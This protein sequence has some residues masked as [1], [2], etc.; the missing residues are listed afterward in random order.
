MKKILTSMTVILCMSVIQLKAQSVSYAK[1]LIEQER[2]LDAAKQLRPLADNGDVEA[3]YLAATL[4]FEG[5][6]V[7]HNDAQ[8]IK[9]A[10]LSANQGNTQAILLLADHYKNSHQLGKMLATLEHYITQ[11]PYLNKEFV[12]LRYAEC[13][14]RGWGVEKDE[15]KAWLLA[16]Q[17]K[18]FDK[19]KSTYT[20]QWESYKYRHPEL[21]STQVYDNISVGRG[22]AFCRITRVVFEAERT[23]VYL[24]FTN[25]NKRVPQSVATMPHVTYIEAGGKRFQ[26]TGSSLYNTVTLG[27]NKSKDYQMYFEPVRRDVNSFDLIENTN[28]GWQWIGVN[29]R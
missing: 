28:G 8:G 20:S 2:Y 27:Y 13:Y 5:K 1:S 29:F 19:M 6:G 25:L 4:F 23:I 26:C 14:M 18:Y 16:S 10:T 9:Y 3:Q 17:N 7:P 12:G 11:H 15:E 21:F 22:P 24:R